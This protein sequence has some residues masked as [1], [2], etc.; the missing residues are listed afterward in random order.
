LR[1]KVNLK[2]TIGATEIS[3]MPFYQVASQDWEYFQSDPKLKGFDFRPRG[4]ELYEL[5]FVRH[6]STDIY[7]SVFVTFPELTEF[8]SNDLFSKHPNK[9]NH[10]LYVGR[11]DDV[12]VLSNGEKLNPVAME[13]SLRDHPSVNGAL[14]VGQGK[15]ST[16][17]IIELDPAAAKK[18]ITAEDRARFVESLWPYAVTANENAPAQ[19]R[20]TIDR[21]M[22]APAGKPFRRAGKGTIQR[23][24]TVKLFEHEINE[25]YQRMEDGVMPDVPKIDVNQDAVS[26]QQ[27]IREFIHI[28]TG[29]RLA[30][31]DQDFFASGMDSLHVMKLTKH[32]KSGLVGDLA[33]KDK[34]NT[35]IIYTNPTLAALAVA[36]KA[37]SH[38]GNDTIN[39]IGIVGTREKRMQELLHKYLDDLPTSTTKEG[40][41]HQ[42]RLTVILT[43]STGSL[44][45]YI[46]D[47]L[48]ACQQVS[49]IYC[50]NRKADAEQIQTEANSARSLISKWGF[51]IKFLQADLSKSCLGLSW[52]DYDVLVKETSIIIREFILYLHSF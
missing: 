31:P 24:T 17:A 44:G 50:L 26:L 27:S 48:A 13:A 14:V 30:E 15:F 29:I 38:N 32:L 34:I 36:L 52:E 1:N 22:V 21:I 45:S 47:S 39:G 20:L 33:P 25:L 37:L 49:R 42:E 51:R 35:R 10:W 46:L 6:P 7:H 12:I 28:V 3:V 4:G 40:R 16:A 5:V 2:N 23:S 18:V 41:T 43:G 8:P 9:S 11:A 19:A